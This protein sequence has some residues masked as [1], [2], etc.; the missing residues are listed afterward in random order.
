MTAYYARIMDAQ[1]GSEAAYK[2]D[3]PGDLMGRTADEIVQV[4]FE[5][6]DEEVLQDHADWELNAV[7]NNRE[8]RVVTAIGSLFP[9]KNDPPIP[10]L[11]MISDRAAAP[12]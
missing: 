4:F 10:F 3:G 8:R 1:T 2:F 9:K 12:T 11:L 6:V 5:D 7:L